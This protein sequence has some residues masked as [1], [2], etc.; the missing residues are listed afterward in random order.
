MLLHVL[1]ILVRYS[2]YL[3]LL[4][5]VVLHARITLGAGHAVITLGA[6]HA[7]ITLGAGQGNRP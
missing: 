5:R 7:V 3:K 4:S 2:M 1:H 6:G